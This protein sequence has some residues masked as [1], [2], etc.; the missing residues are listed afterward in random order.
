[1][2]IAHG[3]L[4]ASP[5]LPIF[6]PQRRGVI[7]GLVVDPAWR[8]RGVGKRLV[9]ALEAWAHAEGAAWVELSVY[10]FN[11]EARRF[12]EALGYAPLRT[13]L[14]KPSPAAD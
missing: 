12:Y 10:D 7:D 9:Q 5:A 3:T 8:R 14:R 2:G 1:M 11:D 4:R 6:V 13:T